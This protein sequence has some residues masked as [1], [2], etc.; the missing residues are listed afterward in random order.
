M[1]PQLVVDATDTITKLS[2][3]FSCSY[4]INWIGTWNKGET[5]PGAKE[6]GNCG[7]ELTGDAER[8]EL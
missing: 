3:R 6:A 7:G 4:Q 8:P 1:S 2:V 5:L